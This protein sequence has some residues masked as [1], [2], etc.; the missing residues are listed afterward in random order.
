MENKKGLNYFF[1]MIAF[2]LG[3][4][5]CVQFDFD[6]FRFK[7]PT[8]ATLLYIIVFVVSIYFIIKGLID[9]PKN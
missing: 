2:T 9:R 3:I 7:K 4:S 5:L 8:Y 1:L 6:T